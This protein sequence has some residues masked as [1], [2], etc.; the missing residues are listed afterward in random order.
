M[1]GLERDGEIW[2]SCAWNHNLQ[3]R[4]DLSGA[5][6][7]SSR[8]AAA[9]RAAST[10]RATSPDSHSRSR[11]PRSTSGNRR[12]VIGGGTSAAEAVIAI[13]SA[14]AAASD[15]SDVYWSYRGDKM[16]KVSQRAGRRVLRRL[17]RQRQRALSARAASPWPMSTIG[18]ESIPVGPDRSRRG[19]RHARR[20]PRSSSSRRRI[21]IACI[22]ED[23]PEALLTRIGVP[24]VAGGPANK[25]RPW[26]ASC[27]K[28]GSR[29]SI[30][31]ATS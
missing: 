22:G 19:R 30:W 21:C 1:T 23:I 11:S 14:K 27:S 5:A 3:S 13:S 24:L 9:C 26:S 29:T 2:R 4:A 16:P 25:S 12:C 6:T 28:R 20:K 18:E 8:S 10:F 15:P 7:S 31:P 17:H